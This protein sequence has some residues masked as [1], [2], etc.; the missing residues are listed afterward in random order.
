MAHEIETHTDGT[1][2][3]VSARQH[4]W[5]RLGTVLPQE[6]TAEEAMTHAQ[7]GG[8]DVRKEPL[9][10]SVTVGEGETARETVLDVPGSFA[11]V[12]THP[13]TGEPEVLGVVGSLYTPVQNEEHAEFLNTLVDEGGAHFETAGSLKGGRQ[14]FVTMKLPNHMLVGGEDQVDMYLAA[15]NSHDGS[16]GFQ[17]MITPVRVVCANTQAAAVRSAKQIFTVRHTVNAKRNIEQVRQ[18]L[19]L[20]FGYQE[21]FQAEAEKMIQETLTDKKFDAA[22]TKVFGAPEK[23]AAEAVKRRHIEKMDTIRGLLTAPTQERIKGTR[24]AGY[25]AIVEYFD[26]VIPVQGSDGDAAAD[27]R[28]FRAIERH[29]VQEAKRSA[30]AALAV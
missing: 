11:S 25:Q 21:A 28:A 26:H 27:A 2:A 20:T 15:R 22:L 24:W 8:W 16:T 30:F 17:V 7:L 4:A 3:F 1:A 18:A 5:H 6:F 13:K 9:T 19:D 23:D 10:T 29:A 12:R 14:V